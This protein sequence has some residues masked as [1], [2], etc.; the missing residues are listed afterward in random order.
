MRACPP[1][2]EPRRR[3]RWAR[4]HRRGAAAASAPAGR[5]RSPPRAPPSG[6]PR[7]GWWPPATTPSWRATP[8]PLVRPAA[9][10]GLAHRPGGVGRRRAGS[11][12]LA[13]GT[14]RRSP[15]RAAARRLAARPAP[16]RSPPAPAAPSRPAAGAAGRPPTGPARSARP[17][18]SA[19][20]SSAPAAP[21]RSFFSAFP[22][23][24]V[25][26]S[27]GAAVLA[28]VPP[29][30]A[31]VVATPGAEPRAPGGLRGRSAAG[32]LVAADPPGPAGR[33]GGAAPVGERGGAGPTGRCRRAGGRGRGRRPAGGAGAG[34]LGSRRL[35]RADFAVKGWARLPAGVP[36]RFAHRSAG[37]RR[38]AGRGGPPLPTT[39]EALGPVAAGDGAERLLL[40]V[41][42]PDGAALAGPCTPP[43]RSARPEGARPGADPARPARALLVGDHGAVRVV[44][45]EG[46]ALRRGRV[47]HC[48]AD[49]GPKLAAVVEDE[50]AGGQ[51]G[52]VPPPMWPR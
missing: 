20:S 38:R 2:Q 7:P 41:P 6:K 19:P 40:R 32:R 35:R 4:P 5:T 46:V 33:G 45:G 30:P 24:P 14:R 13:G 1:E 43:P 28:T 39:A 34:P 31:L 8:V 21:R 50:P 25:R 26:T 47:R 49:D 15:V 27:G 44:S 9:H 48:A 16:A 36:V 52:L 22:G 12:C 11:R 3:P 42:R 29:E 51:R 37:R 17:P 18:G 10:A 23:V